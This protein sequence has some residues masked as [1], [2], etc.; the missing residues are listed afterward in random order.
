MF[1]LSKRKILNNH[2]AFKQGRFPDCHWLLKDRSLSFLLDYVREILKDTGEPSV[3]G[4]EILKLTHRKGVYR[5][6]HSEDSNLSY[7]VKVFFLRHLSHRLSAHLYG[8]DEA[9]NFLTATNGGVKTPE[10][11]GFGEY[12]ARSG[13]VKVGVVITEDLQGY[14]TIGEL[15]EK[16]DEKQQRELLSRIIPVFQSLYLCGCNHIDVNK[17]G[18]ML[19]EDGLFENVFLLDF[20][21]AIFYSKPNLG[22]LMFEA[23][24]FGRSCRKFVSS[25]IMTSWCGELLAVVGVTEPIELL[26]AKELFDYHLH[27]KGNKSTQCTLS[28]KQRKRIR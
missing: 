25:E 21:H 5:V 14:C 20:Q 12:Y 3:E 18:I 23:G 11:V 28:R 27:C 15:L 13:L 2:L 22:I 6:F 24:Y 4:I 26:K 1:F 16:S 9:A 17:D 19:S 10:L 8:L 7:I